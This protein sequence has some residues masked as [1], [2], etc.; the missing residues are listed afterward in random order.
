MKHRQLRHQPRQFRQR[1]A[2]QMTHHQRM[3]RRWILC[4]TRGNRDLFRAQLEHSSALHLSHLNGDKRSPKHH[5]ILRRPLRLLLPENVMFCQLHL[6]PS[7]LLR[8][9]TACLRDLTP[10]RNGHPRTPLLIQGQ[11][12]TPRSLVPAAQDGHLQSIHTQLRLHHRRRRAMSRPE[13]L[14]CERFHARNLAKYFEPWQAT[15]Q[16][17][18]VIEGVGNR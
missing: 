18:A 16:L 2:P 6:N 1:P 13:S 4:D 8:H 5:K 15:H 11:T 14:D 7:N 9:E 10:A 17:D 3:K 12:V